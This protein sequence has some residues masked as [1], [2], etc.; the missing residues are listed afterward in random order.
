MQ[1]Q[2]KY[3]LIILALCTSLLLVLGLLPFS[4]YG[5]D[6]YSLWYPI[7]AEYLNGDGSYH[8][9]SVIFDGQNLA[10]IYGELPFWKLF[11]L[12]NFSIESFLNVTHGIFV[13]IFLI[14]SLTICWGIKKDKS[15]ADIYI[16]LLFALF[17]PVVINR[18]MA[19][20]LNLLFGV[21]PFFAFISLIFNKSLRNIIFCVFCVWCSLSTQAFQILTYHIFYLP[22]IFF[23]LVNFERQRSKYILLSLFVLIAAFSLN[24][25]NFLEMYLHAT[26]SDNLRTLNTKMVYSYI[27]ST[28]KDL[29][30]FI[31]SGLSPELSWRPEGFFHETNYSVGAF[32][33]MLFPKKKDWTFPALVFFLFCIFFLFCMDISPFNLLS[34][35][36]LIKS[37]R[38]PQ[39]IFMILGL[40]IPLWIYSRFQ[41]QAKRSDAIILVVVSIVAQFITFFEIMVFFGLTYFLIQKHLKSKRLALILVFAGLYVGTLDKLTPSFQ[42]H[43]RFHDIKGSILPLVHLYDSKSLRSRT[44]H[45]ETSHPLLVNSVAQTIGIRTVEGYGHPPARYFS[46]YK[47]L[48]GFPISPHSNVFYLQGNVGEKMKL[49]KEFGVQTIVSFGL[50]NELIIKNL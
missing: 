2:H 35:I 3:S 23:F 1:V 4:I 28:F 39:R 36:P 43:S 47:A 7:V 19:G 12:L 44:F 13:I 40:L 6:G 50:K 16:L 18:V 30:Q 27:T 9:S 11:R 25:S 34:D 5:Q 46:K 32:I 45:F 10:S 31:V 37:F 29:P 48:T 33:L 49:L 22:F 17:S 38:V 42:A 15:E 41:Y 8:A 26:G 20:H 14:L 24:Y 21:L